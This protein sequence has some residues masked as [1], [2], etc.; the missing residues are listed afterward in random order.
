MNR[1]QERLYSLVDALRALLGT[2]G[3]QAHWP[4]NSN[5]RQTYAKADFGERCLE[6]HGLANGSVSAAP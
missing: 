5:W 1:T 3:P 4:N 2:A 6:N